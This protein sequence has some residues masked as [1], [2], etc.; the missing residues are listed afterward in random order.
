M[1][2]KV[3]TA[4]LE[5]YN[6]SVIPVGNDKRPL[7]SWRE[8]QKRR[9]TKDELKGWAQEFPNANVGIVTG[10][11]SDLAVVDID[12][13][14]G[15]SEIQK[16]IPD[17]VVP[18]K[19]Q[20]PSGGQH[21][22]FRMPPDKE[23]RLNTRIVPGCDLRAEG[24]YVVAPPS[25]N[26]RGKYKWLDRTSLS[27][28]PI[29]PESYVNFVM[30]TPVHT[31][32]TNVHRVPQVSTSMFQRG[33]RD[34]DLFHVANC[35][36]KGGM[37]PDKA[38]QVLKVLGAHCQFPENEIAIKVKSALE[39][40]ER[41]D[42]NLA[43]EVR[44][45]VMSTS[46]VFLST[47]VHKCLQVST[48]QDMKN[49]S[50]I[51]RRLT[52]EKIIEKY[53]N[54]SGQWRVV[55]NDLEVL[56]W[57]NATGD[58]IDLKMPLGIMDYV[59]IMPKNLIVVAGAPNSGKTALLLNIVRSNMYNNTINYFSSEMSEFEMRD[60]L[61]KFEDIELNQW[62]FSAYNRCSN[63]AD[64]IAPDE[65]NIIDFLELHDEFWKVG[66]M[67]KEIY[68]KLN[69]GIAIIAIQ[70]KRNASVGKGGDITLEK[71]RLYLS[72]DAG[73]ITIEKGKNWRMPGTNP[74][75]LSCL[76]KLVQG[77]KFLRDCDW[78]KTQA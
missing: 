70:K 78:A 10:T 36:I 25:Q 34:D 63:F 67:F 75:G 20:T 42:R 6:F 7:T 3:A 16:Y 40:A 69:K 58:E 57:R 48:R 47:Y 54:R 26:G 41:R 31:V 5:R 11:I 17:D 68:E 55:D 49:V 39:R 66:A 56:D 52:A 19:V 33:H 18:P 35:L 71:P 8:Y 61:L 43:E 29:L 15:Y 24:G 44:E 76:F 12:E 22:Y 30:S 37:A 73:K 14:I 65:I 51:L 59:K 46:G 27:D 4:Y 2:L 13:E 1:F 50:E 9:P 77:S 74:N 64:V 23:I 53:G 38:L 60:R 21:W 28:A 62:R 45:W 72:M 32:S